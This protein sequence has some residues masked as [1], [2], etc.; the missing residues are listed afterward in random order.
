MDQETREMF[1]KVIGILET[2]R[3][4]VVELITDVAGLKA[5]VA[6]LKTDVAGLKTD[7]AELKTSVIRLETRVGGLET[8]VGGL[9][10]RVSGLER[11][12][13]SLRT[14]MNSLKTEMSSLKQTMAAFG[15]RQDEMY[16]MLKSS[17]ESRLRMKALEEK[18]AVS[19]I[20][21]DQLK[22]ES[23]KIVGA[24]RRGA[25]EIL[26]GLGDEDVS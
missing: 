26:Q 7:V 21:R 13:N 14:E 9:E 15:A 10:T 12:S 18:S 4:D 25:Q 11:S 24:L 5:D 23:S 1:G 8:R 3:T 22:M 16:L 17:E 19:I 2:L 20:E 6:G